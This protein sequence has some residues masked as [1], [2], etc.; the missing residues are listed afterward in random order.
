MCSLI[1]VAFYFQFAE[2]A[3]FV[4]TLFNFVLGFKAIGPAF[5][6]FHDARGYF[7]WAGAL[8][9]DIYGNDRL[10]F[11]LFLLCIDWVG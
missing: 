2:D 1:V 9:R 10:S 6:Q 8:A 4:K 7:L 5:F 11:K 3:H